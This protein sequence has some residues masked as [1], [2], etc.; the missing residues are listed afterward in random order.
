MM[1]ARGPPRQRGSDAGGSLVPVSAAPWGPVSQHYTLVMGAAGQ[2][3]AI[4]PNSPEC[5]NYHAIKI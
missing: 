3:A 4:C 1:E 5:Y 2:T